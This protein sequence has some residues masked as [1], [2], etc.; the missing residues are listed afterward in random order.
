MA[1]DGDGTKDLAKVN[2][3]R[4]G[5]DQPEVHY[6]WQADTARYCRHMLRIAPA[7]LLWDRA[8]LLPKP[9][10]VADDADSMYTFMAQR[11][12]ASYHLGCADLLGIPD[13]ITIAH[14][15]NGVAVKATID[16]PFYQR[17]K[18]KIALL[19]SQDDAT[20][21]AA[22]AAGG[23]YSETIRVMAVMDGLLKGRQRPLSA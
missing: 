6:S 21:D 14:D 10:P 18:R 2:A 5:V 7:R 1:L 17:C 15:K 19:E 12:A 9:S 11:F 23:G 20:D 16:L 22:K 3:Y 8:L 4:Q 13:P